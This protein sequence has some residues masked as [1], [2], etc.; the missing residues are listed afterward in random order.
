VGLQAAACGAD[1]V[2]TDLEDFIPL[3]QLNISNNQSALRGVAEARRLEWGSDVTS[4]LPCPDYILMADCIYYEQS[5]EPLVT[6][7]EDLADDRTVVLCCYEIRTTGNKPMLERKFLEL[8][9]RL[10]N[11]EDVP[12]HD[13]HPEYRSEDIR[14]VRMVRK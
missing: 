5:L 9:S 1:C 8:V 12:L 3:I 2:L 14:I 13:Q 10:F 7:M 11:M 6:T 4:F